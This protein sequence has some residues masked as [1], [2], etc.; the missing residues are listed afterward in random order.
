MTAALLYTN[1][2][3]LW[4]LATAGLIVLWRVWKATDPPPG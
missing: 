3:A 4:L 2:W 1:Y